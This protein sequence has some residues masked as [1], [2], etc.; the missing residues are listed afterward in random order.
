MSDTTAD[1]IKEQVAADAE[2]GVQTFS[3]GTN[4]VSMASL[5]ERL[6][7][8]EKLRRDTTATANPSFGLRNTQ[9][10]SPGGGF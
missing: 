7:I 3:D 5:K 9:L 6:E 10:K 8:A 2:S 4:S 1:D